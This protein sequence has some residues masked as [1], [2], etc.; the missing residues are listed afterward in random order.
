MLRMLKNADLIISIGCPP[1]SDQSIASCL[2]S[3]SPSAMRKCQLPIIDATERIPPHVRAQVSKM[4]RH[5]LIFIQSQQTHAG[6][7]RTGA[8]VIKCLGPHP[9]APYQS[10]ASFA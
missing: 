3:A 10:V 2:P 6:R 5:N 1:L 4:R 9:Q 8:M 7:A